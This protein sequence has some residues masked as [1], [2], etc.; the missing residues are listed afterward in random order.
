MIKLTNSIDDIY[1]EL[2]KFILNVTGDC[3]E[4]FQGEL[5]RVPEP[6]KPDFVIMTALSMTRLDTNA[7]G[8][9]TTSLTASEIDFVNGIQLDI[10]L[11]IHGPKSMETAQ[12]LNTIMRDSY[13]TEI[14]NPSVFGILYATNPIHMPFVNAENQ[15]EKRWV[16]T[17]ALQICVKISTVSQFMSNI[18]L[19]IKPPGD[20]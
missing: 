2:R 20:L 14:T 13:A 6:L 10:Q 7:T 17:V 11:D 5:N 15:Y 1:A 19:I 3:V 12:V 18:N 4:V 16:L 8:W 9:D